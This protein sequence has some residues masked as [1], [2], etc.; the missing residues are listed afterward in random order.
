MLQLDDDKRAKIVEFIKSLKTIEDAMEPLKEQRKDLRAEFKQMGWLSKD[1]QRL[2]V[3]A[4]RLM[5]NDINLDELYDVYETLIK[6]PTGTT[7]TGV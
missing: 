6:P 2:A 1:E 3:K 5:R 7:T 4:Y